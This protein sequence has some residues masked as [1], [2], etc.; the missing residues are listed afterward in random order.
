MSIK[1]QKESG[2]WPYKS[3]NEQGIWCMKCVSEDALG[4]ELLTGPTHC[5]LENGATDA[6][7]STV[8]G[9]YAL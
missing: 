9:V 2:P 3:V 6:Q 8:Y 4:G 7:Y 5:W 1:R